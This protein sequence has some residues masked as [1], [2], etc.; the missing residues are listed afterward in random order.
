M[1][2]EI[3]NESWYDLSDFRSY[4]EI[5]ELGEITGEN[6]IPDCVDIEDDWDAIQELHE[7]MDDR[8]SQFHPADWGYTRDEI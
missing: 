7:L 2:I 8:A 4:D 3:N 5:E 6:G 1:R